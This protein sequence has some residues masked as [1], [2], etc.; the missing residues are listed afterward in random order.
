LHGLAWISET[1]GSLA[2]DILKGALVAFVA[3][4]LAVKGAVR[5]FSSQRWWERQEEAY[6]KIVESLSGMQVTLSRMDNS[7]ARFVSEKEQ[8][9]MWAQLMKTIDYL[10]Q[11]YQENAFRIS[12][13]S[14]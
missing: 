6:R 5:Q 14:T 4:W 9:E 1:P 2:L 7:G 11:S 3:S 8:I 13:R 12:T 10:T